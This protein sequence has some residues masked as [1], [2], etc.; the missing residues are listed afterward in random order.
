M[1]DKTAPLYKP[2]RVIGCEEIIRTIPHRYPFLLIDRVE[3][4]EENKRAVG[5]KCVTANELFFHGHFPAKP[6][7]P[8]VLIVEAM[9]QTAAAMLMGLPEIKGKFAWFAGINKAR[10]RRQVVPGDVLKLHIEILRF[11][12]RLARVGGRAFVEGDPAAEAE[13]LFAVD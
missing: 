1:D 6:V 13:M 12:S 11:K 5:V 8:G 4:I 7:M 9:A 10:F 2:C 3:V